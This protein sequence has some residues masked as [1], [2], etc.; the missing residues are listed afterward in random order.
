MCGGGA[1]TVCFVVLDDEAVAEESAPGL[2]C[3]TTG[4]DT[5]KG[6]RRVRSGDGSG[7]E[8]LLD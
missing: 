3:R 4:W 2:R 7:E 6:F 8:R 5:E 1:A